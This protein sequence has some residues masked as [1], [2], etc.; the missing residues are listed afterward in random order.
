MRPPASAAAPGQ[1]K[2][3]EL[4]REDNHH[5][6]TETR[7]GHRDPEDRETHRAQIGGTTRIGARDQTERK[8]ERDRNQHRGSRK[9]QRRG[10][11]LDDELRYRFFHRDRLAKI[12]VRQP[13]QEIRVLRGE[14]PIE[15]QLMTQAGNIGG[16]RGVAQH[17]GHWVARHQMDEREGQRGDAERDRNEC[18]EAA[19]EI[20][21][22]RAVLGAGAS[23]TLAS[24]RR[25]PL[26]NGVKPF[27]RRFI[28]T[29]LSIHQ[30]DT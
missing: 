2:P 15:P 7:V 12:A 22:H 4:E 20:A 14:R 19:D 25:L 21:S 18:G 5:Q 17:R 26:G 6:G 24:E 11:A 27:T 29:T 23:D 28:T 10:K 30:S 3:S 1:R 13:P 8:S 9:L 16:P